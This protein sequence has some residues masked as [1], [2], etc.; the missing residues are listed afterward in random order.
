MSQLLRLEKLFD[1]QGRVAL[2]T[3]GGTGIGWM[4]AEG[5]AA[6]G[7]RVYIT[8]RR[9]DVLEQAAAKFEK[10]HRGE[11]AIIPLPMD[12]T[13]KSSIS[14][15]QEV[16]A[17]KVGRLHILVNNAGQTGP[18]TPFLNDTNAPEH[19]SPE[20]L[21]RAMFD[22]ASFKDWSEVFS[23][24][25]FSIYFM[26][27]AFLGLLAKGSK[28]VPGYTS[29]VVNI[30]SISGINK[31]GQVQLAYNTTKAATAHLTKM[32]ATELALKKVPV[33]VCSVAPGVYESEMTYP[34]ITPDMVDKIGKSIVPQPLQRPGSAQEVA[35]TVIYLVS[36]A[37][38]YTNGQEIV[39]DG[40]YT[41]V[42]PS[43]R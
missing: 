35:G 32:F 10:E 16:I 30:T 15:G 17:L 29:C 4:I 7:A 1:L 12:V 41:A 8:G 36:P 5:L 42:N 14:A 40:G 23:V 25:T 27:T 39:V 3:G 43:T 28:D 22:S 38:C 2:V 19:K 21:G 9:K 34:T 6:N 33:R 37:G 20:T 24:N 26:T 18:V 13:E 31:L 11:G